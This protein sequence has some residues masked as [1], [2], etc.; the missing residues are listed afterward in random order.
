M[1]PQASGHSVD[2]IVEFNHLNF[3][4]L[5]TDDLGAISVFSGRGL[6]AITPSGSAI[7]FNSI[8]DVPGE[9]SYGKG[10]DVC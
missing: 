8:C 2:N 10:P 9:N 7:R 5:D 3:I 6:P 4:G 1:Y